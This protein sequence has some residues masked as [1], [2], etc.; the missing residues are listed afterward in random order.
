MKIPDRQSYMFQPLIS[1]SKVIAHIYK[2]FLI[3]DTHYMLK[4]GV[5]QAFALVRSSK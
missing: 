5:F 1:N 2:L 4:K 3:V